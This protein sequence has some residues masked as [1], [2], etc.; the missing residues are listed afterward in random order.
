MARTKASLPGAV[1]PRIVTVS[2]AAQGDTIVMQLRGD[3]DW[4]TVPSLASTLAAA[5]ALD[6]TNL[7]VDLSEVQ[8][9]NAAT[10]RALTAAGDFMAGQGRTFAL[11]SPSRGAQRILDLCG[12]SG[13][14]VPEGT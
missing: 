1:R 3:H 11:R 13:L 10:I 7:V 8:F 12:A 5:V 2:C 6:N 4:S 14:C 9:I